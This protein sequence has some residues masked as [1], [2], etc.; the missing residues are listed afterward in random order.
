MQMITIDPT[1]LMNEASRAN[2]KLQV[3]NGETSV[4]VSWHKMD[5][6]LSNYLHPLTGTV[7][8]VEHL[9]EEHGI[10]DTLLVRDIAYEPQSLN[11]T[12]ICLNIGTVKQEELKCV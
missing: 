9:V 4:P 8:L 7:R 3:V 2:L 10:A 5:I 11:E 1:M 12:R 6:T